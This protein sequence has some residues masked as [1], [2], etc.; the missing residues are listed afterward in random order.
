MQTVA[1]MAVK[2]EISL[3]MR[4]ASVGTGVMAVHFA[5]ALALV[6]WGGWPAQGANLMAFTLAFV[7]SFFSHYRIT[8]RS[9]RGYG[10]T[11]TRFVVSAGAAY[12]ASAALLWGLE[13]STSLD[14]AVCVLLAAG[15]IPAIT[16]VAGRWWVF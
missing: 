12:A 4:F 8:F 16:Y 15:V 7:L 3:L 11:L 14:A 13:I 9:G 2:D 6:V 5:L 10:P 1:V